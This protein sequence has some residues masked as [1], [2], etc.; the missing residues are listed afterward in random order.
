[1]IWSNI[2][3][4][5]PKNLNSL[6][7]VLKELKTDFNER[8]DDLHYVYFLHLSKEWPNVSVSVTEIQNCMYTHL[9]TIESDRFEERT[10]KVF[11]E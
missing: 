9:V 7:A 5:E 3:I 8:Y 4:P 11:M 2:S 6:F 1:M 10:F